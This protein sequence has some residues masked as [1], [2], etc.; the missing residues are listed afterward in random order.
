MPDPEFKSR[1]IYLADRSLTL[2]KSDRRMGF[3][4]KIVSLK[5]NAGM[6][7]T[8]VVTENQTGKLAACEEDNE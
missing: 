8:G 3:S 4:N 1:C 7:V 6:S 2:M 5:A